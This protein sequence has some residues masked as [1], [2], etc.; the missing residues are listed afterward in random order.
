MFNF[1]AN[2]SEHMFRHRRV[3]VC[4]YQV[5]LGHTSIVIT[6]I[7]LF[8]NLAPLGVV[9]TK[10][11]KFLLVDSGAR[12]VEKQRGLIQTAL[13]QRTGQ[14]K[15]LHQV[16]NGLGRSNDEPSIR[17]YHSLRE[18]GIQQGFLCGHHFRLFKSV[19]RVRKLSTVVEKRFLQLRKS[20]GD[21]VDARR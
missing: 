3:G 15:H 5:M 17:G 18:I 11:C 20:C 21:L 16:L 13:R 14:A 4:T 8:A 9:K 1:A 7:H 2:S 19:S 6:R 10:R 12:L